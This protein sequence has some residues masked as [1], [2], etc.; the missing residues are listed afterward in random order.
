MYS[1]KAGSSKDLTLAPQ[2]AAP[3][4]AEDLQPNLRFEKDESD[5]PQAERPLS[6]EELLRKKLGRAVVLK[7]PENTSERF[8][9]IEHYGIGNKAFAE[10]IEH[11]SA[12]VHALGGL[13]RPVDTKLLLRGKY[14]HAGAFVALGGDFYGVPKDPIS[15][16]V[17]E[18]D[19]QKRF[20]A[21]YETLATADSNE[22]EKLLKQ[23]E[24]E[25]KAVVDAAKKGEKPSIGL[26]RISGSNNI[27]YARIT[28]NNRFPGAL[29]DSRYGDLAEMNFDHFKGEALVSFNAGFKVAVT[30]AE[31]AFEK[32]DPVAK[33]EL[34]VE[35]LAQ[36]LFACHFLTDL[37]SAGHLRTPRKEMWDIITDRGIMGG[38]LSAGFLAMK[39]HNED[40]AYGLNVISDA[41][42]GGWK[43]YGD[44]CYFDPKNDDGDKWVIEAV[45]AALADIFSCYNG[46]KPTFNFQ[47]FLPRPSPVN[48]SP[49]FRIEE[50]DGQREITVRADINDRYCTKPREVVR[51]PKTTLL[52]IQASYKKAK[53]QGELSEQEQADL[54]E[55]GTE[56]DDLLSSPDSKYKCSPQ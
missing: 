1:S 11:N 13:L 24:V 26:H 10:F 21:A 16:G 15:F 54:K 35:S 48:F 14:L 36:L 51:N 53:H 52:A 5:S 2:P 23:M 6:K 18:E 47:Q 9:G 45:K 41:C 43:A 7:K 31:K 29:W 8:E 38:S 25:A 56:L 50:I 32:Q 30:T 55:L 37:F 3:K 46:N 49:M 4:T 44:H 27:Q 33:R 20:I 12:F 34:F 40:N 39:M 17:T 22:V 19:Q 28:Q 42:A